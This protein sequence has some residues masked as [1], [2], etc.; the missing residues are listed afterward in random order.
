[1][2][3]TLQALNTKPRP[4]NVEQLLKI[5]LNY[6]LIELCQKVELEEKEIWEKIAEWFKKEDVRMKIEGHDPNKIKNI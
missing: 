5:M 3:R 4:R 2:K 1:M 6:F